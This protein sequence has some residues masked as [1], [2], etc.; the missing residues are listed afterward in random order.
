MMKYLL[1]DTWYSH[2]LWLSQHAW[3]IK[4]N[5]TTNY[6]LKPHL[7]HPGQ[8]VLTTASK[9]IFAL[10]TVLSNLIGHYFFNQS[11]CSKQP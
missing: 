1:N 8:R 2:T 9:E 7:N 10:E 11:E 5:R 3:V 4:L 6:F